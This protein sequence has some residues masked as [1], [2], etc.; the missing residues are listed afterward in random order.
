[1]RRHL[2]LAKASSRLAAAVEVMF[3]ARE[4]GEDVR[5]DDVWEM[6]DAIVPRRELQSAVATVTGM[7]PPPDAEDDGGWRAEMANRYPTVSVFIKPLTTVI[8]F[9]ANTEGRRYWPRCAPSP[10]RWPTGHTT[11]ARRCCRCG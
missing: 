5:F 3:E 8:E 11:T 9:G 1:M 2:Q 10:T 6:I 4:W 7:V